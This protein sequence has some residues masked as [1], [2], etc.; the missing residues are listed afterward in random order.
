[1]Q[2]QKFII[3]SNRLPVSVTK[4]N[5]TL[6]YT[7]SNGGLASAMSSIGGDQSEQLWIGWPGIAVDDLTPAEKSAITRKLKGFG[8]APVFLSQK[9]IDNF[10]YGYANDTIWPLFHY[11]QSIAKYTNAFWAGYREVNALFKKAVVKYANPDASIWVHDYHL[12]LLPQMLRATLPGSTIGFFLHIPFPSYEIFRL[13][14][15]RAEVLEGLLGAD[16]IGFH[17]YDYARHFLS[18][19]LRI[20]GIESNH[21]SIILNERVIKADAFPLGID[22]NRYA[23]ALREEKTIEE[24]KLLDE[25]YAGKKIILSMDR[26]DYSKGIMKRLEAFDRLLQENPKTHKKVVLFVHAVPSRT[27]VESYQELRNE[28]EKTVSRLNGAY[29]SVDWTPVAYQFKHLPFEQI[30]ALLT[31]ADVALLTPLRDGMNLVAKEYVATKQR[32]PGVLILSEMAGAVD[33]LPEALRINPNDIDAIVQAL[34]IALKMPKKTQLAKLKSMQRR[35]S[36]YTVQRWANDFIEQLE[37]SKQDQLQQSSKLLTVEGEDKIVRQFKKAK[38]RLLLLDYDGTLRGFAPTHDPGQAAP[39]KSLLNLIK[40]LAGLPHT[41]VCIIS[42]RPRK[43]LNSWF[44]GLPLSLAAEHGAWMKYNGEW[45]QQPVSL[46]EHKKVIL[47]VLEHYAERTPGARIEEKDFAL[48]WHYRNV[49]TELAH[50]RNASLR[51]ELSQLLANTDLTIHKGAKII[52]I[53][54]RTVHKGAVVEDLMAIHRA[55]FVL[56]IGD[57]YTD[58]DM[59]R[60]LPEDAYSIKVG[61][62]DTSARYQVTSIKKVL[63]LLRKLAS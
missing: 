11:F 36:R 18:S 2:T 1:M 30:V 10:Y 48:V 54:P 4:E 19:V 17:V 5:G 28:I 62:G 61:L 3:V 55:D 53:K 12:M 46:H 44:Y 38:R 63:G 13:L 29:G 23:S 60:A 59:F 14:P 8:C 51:Y 25:H 24:V 34:K 27:E 41:K 50:A 45:S 42:G 37:R 39:P 57:D 15:N 21:G 52:E 20:L 58:E 56:C 33:E 31:K 9:Q 32:K 7:P 35:L 26:L 40:D 47:P 43:A 22:Y 6:V 49:P 16:L